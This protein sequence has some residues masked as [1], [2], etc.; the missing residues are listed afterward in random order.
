[1]NG[2]IFKMNGFYIP[3]LWS[4]VLNHGKNKCRSAAL[5]FIPELLKAAFTFAKTAAGKSWIATG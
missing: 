4:L 5:N 2:R 1:M 3:R